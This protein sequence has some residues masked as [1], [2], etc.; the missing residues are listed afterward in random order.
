VASDPETWMGT[1]DAARELGITTRTLYRLI[2]EGE[3]PAYKLGRV[4]RIKRGD[5]ESFLKSC[6]VQPGDLKHLYPPRAEGT[7]GDG[8]D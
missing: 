2:D 4:L 3:V 5:I 7:D 8:S 1:Q 6:R